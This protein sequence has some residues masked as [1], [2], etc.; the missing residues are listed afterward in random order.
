[1]SGWNIN[2]RRQPVAFDG[3]DVVSV[4]GISVWT[5]CSTTGLFVP[6]PGSLQDRELG[7]LSNLGFIDHR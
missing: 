5:W 1:L 6:P 2:A 7:T 3:E 4:T